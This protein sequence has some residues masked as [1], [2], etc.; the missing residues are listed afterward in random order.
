MGRLGLVSSL[1]AGG[2]DN[3]AQSLTSAELY[4]PATGKFHA[5][6]SMAVAVY[7]HTATRLSEGSVLITGGVNDSGVVASAE[8]WR[9]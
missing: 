2:I 6:G 3:S 5:A 7:S 8:L 9:P 1:I 4:D